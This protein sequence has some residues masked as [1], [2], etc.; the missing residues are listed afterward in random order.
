M[1]E[2][3]IF[4]LKLATVR[5]EGEPTKRQA[6]RSEFTE[7]EWLLASELANN[8][9]RLL[10]TATPEGREAYAEVAHEAIFRRWDK[11][12]RWIAADRE[13]LGWKPGL[14]AARRA[15]EN[16]PDLSKSDA[17]LMGFALTQALRW[18]TT[19]RDDIAQLDQGFIE[20]SRKADQRRKLRVLAVV[21]GLAVAIGA[22]LAAWRYEQALT[23]FHGQTVLK[24]KGWFTDVQPRVLTV[25][26][27]RALKRG[28]PP[29]KECTSCPEM[30]VVPPGEFVMG[31]PDDEKGRNPR[32]GPQH[33]VVFANR[34]AVSKFELTFDEW[35][36]CVAYGD[37]PYID[38]VWGRG[39]Q[40]AINVSWDNAKTYVAWLSRI[41]GK[42]YRLLSEAEWEYAARAGS[43]TVYPWGDEIG[44][45]TPTAMVAA[46]SGA[47]SRLLRWANSRPTTCATSWSGSRT[48]ITRIT[49][50]RRR[51]ARR[52]RQEIAVP[53]WSAAVP[54]TTIRRSSARPSAS[55]SPP[56]TGASTWVSGLGGRSYLLDL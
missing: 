15:W 17:L 38:S 33:K 46:A 1:G 6:P 14:E 30:L 9:N 29:F 26:A 54:G 51:T 56:T 32:E 8:P 28:D 36:T 42:T 19:R 2:I 45:E 55:G 12:K 37:C 50:K 22:V 5:E 52:G 21:G 16:A 47:T 40:P 13:F 20:L 35:D 39:Q 4:T 24:L 11:L 27:E 43:Q 7:E 18:S 41:T 10:V 25:E 53:T 44:R 49:T 3:A 23:R 48:A 31:S 34:F